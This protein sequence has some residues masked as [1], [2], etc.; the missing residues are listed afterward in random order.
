MKKL[1]FALLLCSTAYPHNHR[2]LTGVAELIRARTDY[3]RMLIEAKLAHSK[4][5][6]NQ[7]EAEK[8][9]AEAAYLRKMLQV[10]QYEFDRVV[11]EEIEVRSKIQEVEW[12]A[13]RCAGLKIGVVH[14]VT[15]E[16]LRRL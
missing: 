16:G 1:I 5:R 11:R 8:K 10:L 2:D 3:Q 4:E 12:W 6:L 14:E 13:S 15:F 9:F 7:A